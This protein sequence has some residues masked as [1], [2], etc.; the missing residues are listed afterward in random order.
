MELK[1]S[2][3]KIT[4]LDNRIAPEG[5]NTVNSH[6]R[7]NY[8]EMT[9]IP[10]LNNHTAN[11]ILNYVPTLDETI[12]KLS[13]VVGIIVSTDIGTLNTEF[14]INLYASKVYP[15]EME[16]KNIKIMT[17]LQKEVN[18]AWID[19]YTSKLGESSSFSD[20]AS[21][22]FIKHSH[23]INEIAKQLEAEHVN[24][25]KFLMFNYTLTHQLSISILHD[26]DKSY[27]IDSIKRFIET[28]TPNIN[29][30]KQLYIDY[31][32]ANEKFLLDIKA[33]IIKVS[34][35][36][37]ISNADFFINKIGD[38]ANSSSVESFLIEKIFTHDDVL[39][40]IEFTAAQ[41]IHKVLL[42]NDSSIAYK[43]NDQYQTIKD[44]A[45]LKEFIKDVHDDA[46]SYILRKK[47]KMIS[48]FQNKLN[49][50]KSYNN[51]IS[52]ATSFLDN[53]A[54]LKQYNFDLTSFTN[55]NFEAIDDDIN[56]IV[57][58]N[59][60]KQ[61]A[62][63][64]LSS[65][66][67]HLFNENTEPHFKSLL[68]NGLTTSQLQSFVGKKLAALNS[69]EDVIGMLTGILNHFDGFTQ[70]AL[71]HKLENLGIKKIYDE[72]NVVTFE[73]DT[74]EKC[75][76]LGS[77]SWCIVRDENYFDQYVTDY[78]NRQYIVYD[79][80][81]TSTDNDSMI[82]FT[83]Q[84][85]GRIYAEHF[86]NDD[87][88][89]SYNKDKILD[90]IQNHTIYENRKRHKLSEETIFALEEIVNFKDVSKIS[91]PLK[92]RNI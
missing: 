9:F 43:K 61:F 85:D 77:T 40:T 28:N 37:F 33:A 13:T 52:S 68:D 31:Q 42:F 8:N 17:D 81:K 69:N 58:K 71:T 38:T 91:K 79:F 83:V 2:L 82:G 25:N 89:D 36:T 35:S 63:S 75:K 12:K 88:I 64:I 45:T 76:K 44:T 54:I 39:T 15:N 51:A 72:N 10:E 6:N 70:E 5:W 27:V 55:K 26:D 20:N 46:L 65:K 59:K 87:S 24:I 48:F 62:F 49:E 23:T 41:K 1:E 32:E 22:V 66:Y 80:N 92:M 86:K 57:N 14:D 47:P 29:S 18:L 74:Y 78:S 73:V 30:F 50:D 84:R 34:P 90:N 11:R 16:K 56:N 67:K 53:Y 4:Q 19:F 3:K 21:D 7:L 60:V